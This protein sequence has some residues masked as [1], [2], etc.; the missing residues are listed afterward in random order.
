VISLEILDI[1]DWNTKDPVIKTALVDITTFANSS[2]ISV[3]EK[4]LFFNFVGR[5]NHT[6]IN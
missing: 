5:F 1:I 6:K 2:Y 4:D 3:W